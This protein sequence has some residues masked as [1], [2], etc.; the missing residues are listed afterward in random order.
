M[1]YICIFFLYVRNETMT[2]CP[3]TASRYHVN[4]VESCIM[5][6]Y[7]NPSSNTPLH[8]H[9]YHGAKYSINPI[10]GIPL[11][12]YLT[13]QIKSF[14]YVYIFDV[15]SNRCVINSRPFDS[16]KYCHFSTYRCEGISDYWK[17]VYNLKEF[18]IGE[19]ETVKRKLRNDIDVANADNNNTFKRPTEMTALW[20]RKYTVLD[21]LVNKNDALL[22]KLLRPVTFTPN[23]LYF[24]IAVRDSM[25]QLFCNSLNSDAICWSSHK[26]RPKQ[27]NC[28]DYCKMFSTASIPFYNI[29]GKGNLV[30]SIICSPARYLN[31][32]WWNLTDAF[33]DYRL[34]ASD[35]VDF[36]YAVTDKNVTANQLRGL[37]NR[38]KN[39]IMR[40]R[41][42]TEKDD[43]AV[44]E[45][46]TTAT[47]SSSF[48]HSSTPPPAALSKNT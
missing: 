17:I 4:D 30:H 35:N 27:M 14:A 5:T 25:Y 3:Y 41:F 20:P 23:P 15:N 36:E 11:Y 31:E 43:N 29:F 26:R 47:A 37:H 1:C 13:S 21:A 12:E 34:A 33:I 19:V 18:W 28:G 24:R 16:S 48:R 9:T 40:Y 39:S 45:Y 8:Y 38:F 42:E 2:A 22:W 32:D 44:A 46:E 6:P 10:K 7:C